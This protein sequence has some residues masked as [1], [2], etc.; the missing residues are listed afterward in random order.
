LSLFLSFFSFFFFFLNIKRY[1]FWASARKKLAD[2]SFIPKILNFKSEELTEKQMR[3]VEKY[4]KMEH[5]N[6]ADVMNVC[7][8]YFY[9]YDLWL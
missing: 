5:F 1:P 6:Y 2:P 4:V 8:D 3:A 7:L 9:L